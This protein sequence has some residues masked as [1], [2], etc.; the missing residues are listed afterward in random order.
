MTTA[1]TGASGMGPQA[2]LVHVG[3]SDGRFWTTDEIN[4][5]LAGKGTAKQLGEPISQDLNQVPDNRLKSLLAQWKVVVATGLAE[6]LAWPRD[7][8]YQV[9]FPE[10]FCLRERTPPV[11]GW[12]YRHDVYLC[13][14]NL[15]GQSS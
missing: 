6:N 12:S 7:A 10:D 8:Q 11:T 9:N 2:R 4:A 5:Q 14:Q 1:S 3:R 15:H 13:G